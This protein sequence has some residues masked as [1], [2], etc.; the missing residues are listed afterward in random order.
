M[1]DQ[2]PRAPQSG[3]YL[4]HNRALNRLLRLTDWLLARR[5][6][7]LVARAGIPA[8]RR[9]LLAN[10]AHLGDV[11]LS[12]AV[13]PALR[14]AFPQARIGFLIGTWARCLLDHSLVDW[15]HLVDHWKLNRARLPLW[16]KLRHYHDMRRRALREIRG[17]R[18]DVALDLYYYFPNSIPLLWQAGIP[19]RIGYTSG[20]FGPLLTHGLEWVPADRHV[21]AY[22]ADLLRCLGVP[23][24][25]LRWRGPLL[26]AGDEQLP[27]GVREDFRRLGVPPWSFLIF[28]MG[29]AAV[30]KE[31]PL[32]R[33]RQLAQAVTAEGHALVFTGSAGRE[34][35]HSDQVS[36]GLPRCLNLCG[37]LTWQE[38]VATIRGAR[39]LVGVDSVAG[40]VA[41]AVGTPCVVVSSGITNPAHWGPRGVACRVLSHPVPCAPCYRSRGCEGMECVRLV[42][43]EQVHTAIREMLV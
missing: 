19:C 5:P 17:N 11:L 12:L 41:A 32:P 23:D 22:Q 31:W 3:K 36:A 39:L 10:G 28:H 40:H 16:E 37:R 2:P 24:S 33:W 42:A 20:G 35:R 6:S 18:Y 14:D 30:L 13:V 38:F 27:P 25:D 8:P 7:S 1:I 21:T 9:I 4:V 43:V 26:P 34:Q 29:T 15:V